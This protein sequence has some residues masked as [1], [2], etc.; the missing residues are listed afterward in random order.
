[1]HKQNNM[2]FK[3]I[4]SKDFTT[5]QTIT[6]PQHPQYANEPLRLSAASDVSGSSNRANNNTQH[7]PKPKLHYRNILQPPIIRFCLA[8]A[9]LWPLISP[10]LSPPLGPIRHLDCRG[11]LP[12][13]FILISFYLGSGLTAA[14]PFIFQLTA[15][16]TIKQRVFSVF[17]FS[18]TRS[19]R[20]TLL[21]AS[22]HMCSF[23]P[24]IAFNRLRFNTPCVCVYL[25]FAMRPAGLL[26]KSKKSYR[27]QVSCV[28]GW[29]WWCV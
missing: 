10:P 29:W 20:I 17:D 4:V 24:Y 7:A 5:F 13:L 14:G 26:I 6:F 23:F 18:S 15:A 21:V 3:H 19:I 16:I 8:N 12:F 27:M 25:K 22:R 28:H 9:Y 11:R 1:M 2:N